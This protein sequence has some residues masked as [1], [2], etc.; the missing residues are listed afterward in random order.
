MLQ[1]LFL[2]LLALA[3]VLVVVAAF[4]PLRG[5]LRRREER[6]YDKEQSL[7]RVKECRADI[8]HN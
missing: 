1:N 5:W 3:W 2:A 7:I 4:C 6:A 8:P